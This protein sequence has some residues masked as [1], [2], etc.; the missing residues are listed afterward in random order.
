MDFKQYE[1]L[2][3]EEF[4]NCQNVDE[5][6]K[7]YNGPNWLKSERVKY[8]SVSASCEFSTIK[9]HEQLITTKF[10][11]GGYPEFEQSGNH[12]ITPRR[13]S[14]NTIELNAWSH[15]LTSGIDGSFEPKITKTLEA[16]KE[17]ESKSIENDINL[18]KEEN[19]SIDRHDVHHYTI[20]Y[21]DSLS[22]TRG[23]LP[24]ITI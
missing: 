17:T 21:D 10:G 13:K 18:I 19:G 2:N 23:H 8:R 11:W 24:K 22:T 4:G 5:I 20:S 6:M 14:Q 7:I 16:F 1:L 12:L 15:G 3:H 9:I